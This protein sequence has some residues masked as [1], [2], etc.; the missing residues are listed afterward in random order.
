MKNSVLTTL[1]FLM[2]TSCS[3][4]KSAADL[5]VTHGR[6]ESGYPYVVQIE[7]DGIGACT[8]SF[9]SDSL[10]ITAAH[11]VD[12]AQTVT[13][14]NIEVQREQFFIHPDWPSPESSCKNIPLTRYDVALVRFPDGSYKGEAGHLLIRSPKVDEEF[15]LVGYGTNLIIP[16]ERFC[17]LQLQPG[18]VDQCGIVVGNRVSGAAYEYTSLF[19]FPA[20]EEVTPG[21]PIKC[22]RANLLASLVAAG[23]NFEDFVVDNCAGHFHDRNYRETGAGEKRSGLNKISAIEDGVLRFSGGISDDPTGIDV[24]SGAGD[25]GGPLFILEDGQPRIAGL[26]HG[27]SL[28]VEDNE[29]RKNTMYVD[30][31]S[32]ISWLR[33]IVKGKALHFSDFKE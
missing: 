18:D 30:L 32:H 27:G 17:R 23:T 9:V 4:P 12:R 2:M 31:S 6:E 13:W 26:T 19:T 15:T 16:F 22:S 10:L 21:C 1:G 24:A 25:S 33:Q 11:C 28:S 14:N 20:K 7:M 8:G 29:F 5:K 3:I